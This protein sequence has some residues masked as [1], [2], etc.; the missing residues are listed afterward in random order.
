LSLELGIPEEEL[1]ARLTNR[2]F[3]RYQH[4]AARHM[5]PTR[6]IQMQ[7]AQLTMW[8]A[9]AAGKEGSISDYLFEPRDEEPQE[10]DPEQARAFFGFNPVQKR[11]E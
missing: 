2:S 10:A 8:S 3:R 5:L 9:L 11:T 6:R 1:A 7:I 4:Y